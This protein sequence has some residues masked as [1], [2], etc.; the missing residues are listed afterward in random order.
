[1]NE[2]DVFLLDAGVKLW[3]FNGRTSNIS[4]KRRASELATLLRADRGQSWFGVVDSGP[5]DSTGEGAEFWRL[6]GGKT[7]LAEQ[8]A[9]SDAEADK[10]ASEMRVFRL[11]DASGALKFAEVK[12]ENGA[13]VATLSRD[14]VL[15]SNDVFFIDFNVVVFAWVGKSASK[16]ERDNVLRYADAYV[17]QHR[18]ADDTPITR[19]LEGAETEP[20]LQ[21]FS[22]AGKSASVV[23]G[24]ALRVSDAPAGP[25]K[26][27]ESG[28]SS[29][30]FL[31][32]V[33]LLECHTDDSGDFGSNTGEFF[34]E[35]DHGGRFPSRGHMKMTV[36]DTFGPAGGV[37]LG[38]V[39]VT[40]S[41]K[42]RGF[43]TK[44]RV[45]EEDPL[46]N[47]KMLE[48][49]IDLPLKESHEKGE[50]VS[51]SGKVK[52]KYAVDIVPVSAW[53]Q[54]GAALPVD[55]HSSEAVDHATQTRTGVLAAGE[56]P[57]KTDLA[58]MKAK[59]TGKR[60][61]VTVQLLGL[62]TNI[63][64]DFLGKT[65][66][67][68]V[69]TNGT[70]FPSEGEFEMGQG[71]VLLPPSAPVVFRGMMAAGSKATEM[72]VTFCVCEKDLLIDDKVVRTTI[73]V[74]LR[75]GHH[76][77]LE[78]SVDGKAKARIAVSV[79]ERDVW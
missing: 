61:L 18:S 62:A 10:Q 31:C 49:E 68:Y 79:E 17:A 67:W 76:Q 72:P 37:L 52:A 40:A 51:K 2:N 59:K 25:S 66:K 14:A 7:K 23:D 47:D 5:D 8:G 32:S 27:A 3:Q 53:V 45:M 12:G 26:H 42:V 38:S 13:S 60:Q 16:S 48:V 64:G 35:T 63:S 6:L 34:F 33:T 39:V 30:S 19:I 44:L 11:S 58:H 74:P 9:L 73:P 4:E 21:L 50:G 55:P 70:R 15:N 22:G 1:M 46:S 65:G 71:D 54:H 43:A 56:A 75:D 78:L 20:F 69:K 41:D 28:A 36:G 29:G 24:P 77:R 57:P